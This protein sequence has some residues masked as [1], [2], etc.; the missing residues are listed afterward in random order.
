MERVRHNK[1]EATDFVYDVHST[2]SPVLFPRHLL[3][4][5]LPLR[6]EA[7]SPG[8]RGTGD[9][10][11]AVV[12]ERERKREGE[13][14]EEEGERRAMPHPT[15]QPTSQL[16]PFPISRPILLTLPP[17]VTA[18]TI[19]AW[20]VGLVGLAGCS[21]QN[22]LFYFSFSVRLV[23]GRERARWSSLVG[24]GVQGPAARSAAAAAASGDVEF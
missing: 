4:S 10:I 23:T 21:A 19:M 7:D 8:G 5:L 22:F 15:N 17:A 9:R 2:H 12:R 14:E 20:I 6:E 1:S 24:W 13:G 16:A 3:S 18:R 11:R